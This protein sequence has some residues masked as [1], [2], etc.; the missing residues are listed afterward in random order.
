ML[1]NAAWYNPT[2]EP[3]TLTVVKF[4]EPKKQ[5][6]FCW[7]FSA[8]ASINVEANV[9]AVKAES[10]RGISAEFKKCSSY[11][12]PGEAFVWFIDVEPMV[13]KGG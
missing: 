7:G 12:V 5:V 4:F 6:E 2:C 1:T 13:V 3:Y 8:E 10:K 11:T 9:K